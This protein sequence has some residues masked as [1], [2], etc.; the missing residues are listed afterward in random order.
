MSPCRPTT[1]RQ[2][3]GLAD[4]KCVPETWPGDNYDYFWIVDYRS[5]RSTPSSFKKV[6]QTFAK[7]YEDL[8]AND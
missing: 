6:K 7:P 3:L 8:P 2:L 5:G 1:L 4:L